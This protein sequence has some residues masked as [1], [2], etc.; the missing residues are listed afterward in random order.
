MRRA[1][2][3][4]LAVVSLLA[5]SCARPAPIRI[6]MVSTLTGRAS[7]LGLSSRSGVTL[8]VEEL[9]AAGG[10]QGR[11][12]EL[13]IRD[14][15]QKPEQ[16]RQAVRE[17]VDAGVVAMIGPATSGMAAATLADVDRAQVLMVSPTVTSPDFGG[18][19]DWFVML[20]NTNDHSAAR[21]AAAAVERAGARRVA[22][23]LD[24]TNASFTRTYAAAFARELSARGGTAREVPFASGAGASFGALAD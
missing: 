9:N 3:C 5:A 1:H 6:G 8:A 10:I 12:I 21:I 20:M 15:G 16:A 13:V 19:D 2:R 4:W 11:P 22:V 18:R 17:L 7:D 24:T 23:V 14:D